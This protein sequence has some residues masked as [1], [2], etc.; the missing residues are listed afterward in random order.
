MDV[1]RSHRDCRLIDNPLPLY[2]RIA[3]KKEPQ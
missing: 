1:V 3:A 2:V